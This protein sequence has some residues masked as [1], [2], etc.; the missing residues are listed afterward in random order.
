[1]K[2]SRHLLAVLML[3]CVALLATSCHTDNAHRLALAHP[4]VIVAEGHYYMVGTNCHG[5]FSL[6]KSANLRQWTLVA[7]DSCLLAQWPIDGGGAPCSAPR[8]VQHGQEYVL[9]FSAG[10]KI[11]LAQS[12]R[13]SGPYTLRGES[14]TLSQPNSTVFASLFA[15]TDGRWY[16]YHTR[17]QLHDAGAGNV[18][19]VAEFDMEHFAIIDSTLTQCLHATEHWELD[20]D[21]DGHTIATL[22]SPFV[23]K[24][25]SIYYL[26]Y[27]A[28]PSR[29]IYHSVGYATAKSPLGPWERHSASPVVHM[30]VAEENGTGSG[31][32]F[33]GLDKMPYYLYQVHASDT[34]PTPYGVRFIP[35]KMAK[36]RLTGIFHITAKKPE[37]IVVPRLF[38]PQDSDE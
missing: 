18:I 29:S 5:G 35:L 24:R 26:H 33:M 25:D 31:Q 8:I 3:A 36:H 12:A 6:F 22:E 27:S 23:T 13:V 15:D 34:L 20:L 21:A 38:G 19:Y 32:F 37:N 10:G 17:H 2:T 7:A 28:C 16:L 14:D 4:S 1:M 30:S 11:F 9:T